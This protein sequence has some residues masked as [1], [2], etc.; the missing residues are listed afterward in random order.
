MSNLSEISVAILA[1]GLGTRLA[2]VLSGTQKVVAKVRNHPFLEY[3]LSQL[4]K[5]GFKSVVICTGHLGNQVK[6]EFGNNYINLSL[7]YSQENSELDTAG[8][9]R[10]ALSKLDSEDIL[11]MNGDSYYDLNLQSFYDFHLKK[12][13]KISIILK[14]MGDTSRY[15]RVSMDEDG[16]VVGFEEKGKNGEGYINGGI[17]F[18]KKSHLYEIPEGRP[19][20]FEKEM[21][22]NWIGKGTYGFK[23]EGNF[24]DIGT[25]QTYNEAEEFFS[26]N[27]L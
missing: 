19:V 1:G 23:A 17:Y 6:R 3:I 25:P 9:I 20:S 11:I 21:F 13:A 5:A 16:Q 4:N 27:P 26:Q 15:G 10:L 7:R 2:P 14:Q 18:I 8:A 12:R 24:I 22:P